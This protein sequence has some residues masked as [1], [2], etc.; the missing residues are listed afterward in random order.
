MLVRACIAVGSN[1]GDRAASLQLARQRLGELADTSVV[2]ASSVEETAPLG[3]L[4]QPTYLNQMVLLETQQTAVELLEACH[5]IE[6]E[7]GRTRDTSWCSRTLDLDIVYFGDL[8]CD[9]PDLVLPHPGLRDRSFWA[10]QVA[11]VEAHD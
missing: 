2:R 3:G 11:A 6:R 5:S 4:E 7:A 10:R 9:L 1:L 8:V